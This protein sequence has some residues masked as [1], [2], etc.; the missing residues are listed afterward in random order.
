MEI[1]GIERSLIELLRGLELSHIDVDLLLCSHTGPL[2]REIPQ[3]IRLL[4]EN[5]KLATFLRPI[6]AIAAQ[7]PL[8]ACARVLAKQKIRRRFPCPPYGSDAVVYALLQAYWSNSNRLLPRVSDDYDAVISFQWPHHLAAYHCAAPR[9]LAWVHTDFTK[10]TLDITA[11]LRVWERFDGIACVSQGV[12][13]SFCHVHPSLRE[14]CFVFENLLDAAALR[15]RAAAYSPSDFLR[16]P[17][18]SILLT[19]GRNCYAKAFD[20]ALR[21]AQ[22]MKAMEVRFHWYIIGYGGDEQALP[23]LA[24]ELDVTDCFTFL[25]KRENPAPYIAACDLYVQ[26]SRY[27]GKAVTVMEALTLGKPVAVTDFPTAAAQVRDGY[28]ARIVPLE[29][30][31]AAESIAALLNDPAER[32]RLAENAAAGDYSSSAQLVKLYEH[33]FLQKG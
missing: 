13:E 33:L 10:T 21:I 14:R 19:V 18:G 11:D 27:E 5:A 4:P 12:L 23:R 17:G 30:D 16:P 31:G 9:K 3:G 6:A 15:E 25:G 2:L 32:R 8:F 24:R 1:G 22:K 20:N 28:D 26:P 7:H 29:N